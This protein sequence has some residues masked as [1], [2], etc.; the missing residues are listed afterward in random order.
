MPVCP[1]IFLNQIPW[2]QKV[3][4]ILVIYHKILLICVK[5]EKYALLGHPQTTVVHETR[6]SKAAFI[7]LLGK[8]EPSY[9][10]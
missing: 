5:S 7:T 1:S 4:K 6:Q 9:V 8:V 2:I 3:A 10:F